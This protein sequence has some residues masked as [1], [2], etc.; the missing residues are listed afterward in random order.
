MK[1]MI[2][3][4]TENICKNCGIPL[5]TL[6]NKDMVS[7]SGRLRDTTGLTIGTP[8]INYNDGNKI[9][10]IVDSVDNDSNTYTAQIDKNEWDN[11]VGK[12]SLGFSIE[13]VK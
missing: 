1:E 4:L 2:K 11:M 10:G 5:E 8:I 12:E 6:S 7:V 13:I 3:E 9:I